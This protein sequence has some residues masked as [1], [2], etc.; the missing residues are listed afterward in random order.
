MVVRRPDPRR[1]D[2]ARL[3]SASA[4]EEVS[5]SEQG[6]SDWADSLD[7]TEHT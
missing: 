6:L 5:L 7:T 4:R 1:W 2:M 3:L